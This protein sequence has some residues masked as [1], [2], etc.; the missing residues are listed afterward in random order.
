MIRVVPSLT[1]P[2]L[3]PIKSTAKII[4]VDGEIGAGK[5]TFLS[6][7]KDQYHDKKVTI[8]PEPVELWRSTGALNEFYKDPINKAYEFQSFATVTRITSAR[9]IVMKNLDS[10]VFLIER[11]PL[12]DKHIFMK[13]QEEK[14]PGYQLPMYHLWCDLWHQLYPLDL[15]GANVTFLVLKPD[16]NVCM[17]RTVNR[18]RREEVTQEKKTAGVSLEYQTM[19][20]KA[21]ENFFEGA[22]HTDIPKSK[23][24]LK[25]L[26]PSVK[27]LVVSDELA[28]ADFTTDS[29]NRNQIGSSIIKLIE[30]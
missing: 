12:T 27:I 13:L 8:I 10:D 9:D 15:S 20:R 30:S 14:I 25:M 1:K 5:T 19:L 22:N 24:N 26:Y 29:P 4:V 3:L 2:G 21:H 28:N 11:S 17:N 6:V 23:E 7:L 18:G 16:L